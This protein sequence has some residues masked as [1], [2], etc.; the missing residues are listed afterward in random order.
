MTEQELIER[1]MTFNAQ[2]IIA[3][4]SCVTPKMRAKS[5]DGLDNPFRMG[6]GKDATVLVRK[7]QSLNG[8]GCPNFQRLVNNRHVKVGSDATADF[9]HSWFVRV[10]NNGKPTSLVR[11]KTTGELYIR[12]V[13]MHT[14]QAEYTTLTGD[15]VSPEA[16]APWLAPRSEYANQNLPDGEEIPHIVLKLESIESIS[17]DGEVHAITR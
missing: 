3:I 4:R 17:I 1:L 15:V 5:L 7:R 11:H 10:E 2:G 16:I 14:G 6:R 9:G 13:P 12:F 8:L